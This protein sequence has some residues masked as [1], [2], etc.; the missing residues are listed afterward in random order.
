VVRPEST[1]DSLRCRPISGS[2]D[3]RRKLA[4]KS[5]PEQQNASKAISGGKRVGGGGVEPERGEA[6]AEGTTCGQGSML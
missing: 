4:A 6:A 3:S 5:F 2:P 1:D